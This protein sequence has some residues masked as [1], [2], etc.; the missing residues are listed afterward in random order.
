MISLSP[1]FIP[2]LLTFIMSGG[3]LFF[4]IL[5][6][7]IL[8]FIFILSGWVISLC[9]HEFGHAFA[10]YKG[11]D[12]T[13]PYM[14]YLSFDPLR[15]MDPQMSIILPVLIM[16]MGGFGFPGG[17]VYIN[18]HLLKNRNWRSFAVAA[19]P[20]GT[21]ACLFVLMLPLWLGLDQ[22]IGHENF[23]YAWSYLALI[24]VFVIVLNLLPIPGFDGYGIIEPFL[25]YQTAASLYNYK[26]Y[27]PLIFLGILMFIPPVNHGLWNIV[28][29]LSKTL[30]IETVYAAM[31]QHDFFFFKTFFRELFNS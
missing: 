5:S 24:E 12:R 14:G 2:I 9:V 17:A 26:Y 7:P 18:H 19:G 10:A 31:G 30:G 8:T 16:I 22:V 21:L 28:F 3:A 13:I 4:G 25:P 1:H 11:G 29:T 6:S 20:L 23:W 27:G 15:Y